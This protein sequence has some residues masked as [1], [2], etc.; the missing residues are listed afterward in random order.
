MFKP[1]R[2]FSSTLQAI[3]Q[4]R[5]TFPV[6]SIPSRVVARSPQ[7]LFTVYNPRSTQI[8]NVIP[9]SPDVREKTN[10]LNKLN[11]SFQRIVVNDFVY[12]SAGEVL[13][14]LTNKTGKISNKIILKLVLSLF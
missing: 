9:L 11:F 12:D 1:I 6:G 4:L 3:E 8:I 10:L 5:V 2:S 13:Y 7:N 14:I